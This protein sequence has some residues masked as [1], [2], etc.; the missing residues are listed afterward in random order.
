MRFSFTCKTPHNFLLWNIK[1]WSFSYKVE[2]YLR[3][4]KKIIPIIIWFSTLEEDIIMLDNEKSCL[5][6]WNSDSCPLLE[7]KNTIIKILLLCSAQKYWVALVNDHV[8]TNASWQSCILVHAEITGSYSPGRGWFNM[9][10]R[11]GEL[12]ESSQSVCTVVFWFWLHFV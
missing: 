4:R 5:C 11:L 12:C 7:I 3:R 6:S 2:F 8:F 1:K 9:F 10:R